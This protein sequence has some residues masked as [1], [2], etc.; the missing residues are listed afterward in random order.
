MK[1]NSDQWKR[2]GDCSLCAHR[3]ERCKNRCEPREA[4][5]MALIQKA[6]ILSAIAR[7]EGRDDP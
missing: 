7:R 2:G 6:L 5:D 3:G 1:H 4:R